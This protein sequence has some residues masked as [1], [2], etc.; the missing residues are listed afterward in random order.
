MCVYV[1][2]NEGRHEDLPHKPGYVIRAHNNV[3]A[4]ERI[5]K[6]KALDISCTLKGG[7][8]FV[9]DCVIGEGKRQADRYSREW[10]GEGKIPPHQ[11]CFARPILFFWHSSGA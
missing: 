9:P 1:P 6:G 4:Q 8:Y 5:Y 7:T 2:L 10:S 11:S 3:A